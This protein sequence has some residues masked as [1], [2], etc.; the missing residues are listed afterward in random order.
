MNTRELQERLKGR[1][2]PENE[3]K[4]AN[5]KMD[6]VKA[7]IGISWFVALGRLCSVI[8]EFF[9]ANG[10]YL[11]LVSVI[12]AFGAWAF[13]IVEFDDSANKNRGKVANFLYSTFYLAYYFA[14]VVAFI[15]VSMSVGTTML[16]VSMFIDPLVN[17]ARATYFGI[18]S[19][20][21]DDPLMRYYF[22]H[23]ALTHGLF[24]GVGTLV[25]TAF[26]LLMMFTAMSLALAVPLGILGIALIIAA[27]F[28]VPK[29]VSKL[30]GPKPQVT[31]PILIDDAS[32]VE[33]G[34]LPALQAA[35]S[36]YYANTLTTTPAS[37]DELIDEINMHI[38]KIEGDYT[39][40]DGT[41]I[42]SIWS[43]NGKRRNKISALE[44]LKEIIKDVRFKPIPDEA[45]EQ[46]PFE[47]AGYLFHYKD[48]F[49]LCDT[50]AEHVVQVYPGAFQSFN[51]EIGDTQACFNKLFLC[52]IKNDDLLPKD[53]Q[54]Y[55][56]DESSVSL[57]SAHAF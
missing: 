7:G 1:S 25:S 37:L 11:F 29:I 13:S 12:V 30:A 17:L 47:L 22:K 53:R 28:V 41:F 36:Y 57:R 10:Q 19:R 48:K 44:F 6:I 26:M 18:K 45:S 9:R 56:D 54:S 20:L 40:E 24:A 49:E 21:T 39:R 33:L 51:K 23:L 32:D 38:R 52:I 31:E 46:E 42:E 50:I 34:L 5:R 15:A 8:A 3:M 35:P 43:Q 4:A 27:A 16:F 55:K 2:R 14:V